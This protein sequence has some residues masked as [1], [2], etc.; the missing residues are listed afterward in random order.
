MPREF[1]QEKC[2][3][4]IKRIFFENLF[5]IMYEFGDTAGNAC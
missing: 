1:F 4:S 2:A 5:L 3:Y